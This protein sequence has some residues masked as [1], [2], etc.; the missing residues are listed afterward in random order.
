M[1]FRITIP[2]PIP[3]LLNMGFHLMQGNI[4]S[5]VRYRNKTLQFSA[6]GERTR[7]SAGAVRET[8]W[9][10]EDTPCRDRLKRKV[11]RPQPVH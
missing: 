2:I 11:G 4:L 10:L 5:K 9:M 6:A 7:T 3:I 8:M 1:V